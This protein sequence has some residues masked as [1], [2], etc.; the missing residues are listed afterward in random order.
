MR[1]VDLRIGEGVQRFGTG[2]G[3]VPEGSGAFTKDTKPSPEQG[4]IRTIHRGQ[5]TSEANYCLKL[6]GNRAIKRFAM[7]WIGDTPK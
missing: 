6:G 3:A 1:C 2:D 4:R 7:R 5:S